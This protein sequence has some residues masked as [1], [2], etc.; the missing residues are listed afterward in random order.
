MCVFVAGKENRLNGQMQAEQKARLILAAPFAL[1]A[2]QKC[3]K[4]FT[5]I[6]RL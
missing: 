5:F 2:Q 1:P 6:T 3:K 4:F